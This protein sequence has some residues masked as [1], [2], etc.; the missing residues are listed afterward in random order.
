MEEYQKVYE[1]FWK[2][3][4]EKDGV[5]DIEQV[6]IELADYKTLLDFVPQVYDELANV[7]KP[8]TYPEY[9]ISRVNNRMIDRQ[10]AFDDLTMNA[11]NG[12]V[13]LTVKELEDYFLK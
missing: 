6:K 10:M 9:I 7:S 1:E 3:L 5:L 8:H 12:E 13:A 2:K 4:V 11:E